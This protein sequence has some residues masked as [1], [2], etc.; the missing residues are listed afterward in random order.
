[1]INI[2]CPVVCQSAVEWMRRSDEGDDGDGVGQRWM[3][4]VGRRTTADGRLPRDSGQ[5]CGEGLI[6]RE[7]RE[8][9]ERERQLLLQRR[10]VI[11]NDVTSLC[12]DDV[13]VTSLTLGDPETETRPDNDVTASGELGGSHTTRELKLA[14]QREEEVG[15]S[16]VPFLCYSFLSPPPSERRRRHSVFGLSVRVCACDDIG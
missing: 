2:R 7:I 10:Q 11:D 13:S 14:T 15:F 3:G 5:G 4:L 8:Q 12:R 1:M 6:A 16:F 9:R